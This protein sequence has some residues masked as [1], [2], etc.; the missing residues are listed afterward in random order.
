MDSNGTP[1]Q[2]F[3]LE[4]P[5]DGGAWWA[6]VHGVARVGRNWA[7]SLSLSCIREGNGNPLQCSCLENPRDGEAWWAAICGVAQSR[8]WLKR[9]SSNLAVTWTVPAGVCTYC[10]KTVSKWVGYHHWFWTLRNVINSVWNPRT[11]PLNR[12]LEIH[13]ILAIKNSRKNTVLT[14]VIRQDRGTKHLRSFCFSWKVGAYS[15][16]RSRQASASRCCRVALETFKSLRVGGS[17]FPLSLP[18][19]Y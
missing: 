1:L 15:S 9:L 18:L 17:F 7:T 2:Y 10:R 19:L 6:V 16:V 14:P 12:G 3:C 4:N 13:C 11:S 8:T 5:V